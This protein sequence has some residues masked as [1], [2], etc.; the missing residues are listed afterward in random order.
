MHYCF[1][2]HA[3]LSGILSGLLCVSSAFYSSIMPPR[4]SKRSNRPLS[5]DPKSLTLAELNA[6]PR[7][8]FIL[9]SSSRNL[10]C[11]GTKTH[12]AQRVYECANG[13]QIQVTGPLHPAPL[14]QN[15][16]PEVSTDADCSLRSPDL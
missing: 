11:P 14:T 12:F 5:L 15:V 6:L 4:P 8:S 1:T 16:N 10:L 3:Q 2:L 13:P 7:N 9:L